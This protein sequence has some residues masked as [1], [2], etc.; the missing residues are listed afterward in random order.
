MIDSGSSVSFISDNTVKALKLHV[1]PCKTNV[2]LASSNSKGEILRWC[3][4][5]IIIENETNPQVSVGI[6]KNLCT[7]L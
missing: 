3:I 4:V 6:M 5:H 2:A 1:E 7:D